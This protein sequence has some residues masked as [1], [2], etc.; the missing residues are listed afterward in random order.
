[1]QFQIVSRWSSL[2]LNVLDQIIISDSSYSLIY[3]WFKGMKF[4]LVQKWRCPYDCTNVIIGENLPLLWASILLGP[5]LKAKILDQYSMK[6][7]SVTEVGIPQLSGR[8]QS[9]AR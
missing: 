9:Q 6:S 4:V 1:M 8:T 5:Y 7:A 2:N 3:D